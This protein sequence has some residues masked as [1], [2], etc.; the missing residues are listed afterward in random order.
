MIREAGMAASSLPLGR[1][2]LERSRS[3]RRHLMCLV[4]A[5]RAAVCPP[6]IRS[7]WTSW[8]RSGA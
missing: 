6:L 1:R 4:P 7:S 8:A 5:A 3:W 2:V